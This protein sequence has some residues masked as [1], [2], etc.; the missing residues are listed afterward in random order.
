MRRLALLAALAGATTL[1][2]PAP[3]APGPLT[4]CGYAPSFGDIPCG[5]VD[6]AVTEAAREFRID[7]GRFRRMVRCES[8]FSPHVGRAH[9]GLTQQGRGFVAREYPRFNRAVE[10]DVLGNVT[11][12]FDNARTAAFVIAREGYGQWT[13]KG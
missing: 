8:R 13:C 2:H 7:E 5:E 3:A 10:P 9:R 4:A 6:R 12:P 1:A 11:S